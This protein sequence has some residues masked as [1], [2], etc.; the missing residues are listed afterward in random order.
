MAARVGLIA[1]RDLGL[2]EFLAAFPMLEASRPSQS[3][4][5]TWA[6]FSLF[7]QSGLAGPRA[8]ETLRALERPS[9]QAWTE[10]GALWYLAVYPLR[11][12][13]F[14]HV[15]YFHYNAIAAG[16]EKAPKSQSLRK[17][18]ERYEES[19]LE[20]YRYA[21]PLPEGPVPR[22]MDEHLRAR[23]HALSNAL[24]ACGVR[25]ERALLR[26]AIAGGSVSAEEWAWDVGNLPRLADAIGLGEAFAGWRD[27]LEEERSAAARQ[28]EL[29]EAAR[30]APKPDRVQPILDR[31]DGAEPAPVR[32]GPVTAAPSVL[33]LLPWSCESEVEVGFIVRPSRA[34]K[35]RWPKGIFDLSAIEAGGEW[36][37][38]HP[39]CSVWLREGVI[40]KLGKSFAALPPGT[41]LELVSAD[42]PESD[43][44][45]APSAAASM[46]FRGVIE[47][48]KWK[49]THA[50]P[51]V[52]R[53]ELQ[54]ALEIFEWI[55]GRTALSTRSAA[56]AAAVVELGRQGG[57]FGNEKKDQPV[58]S[59]RTIKV[60]SRHW[61]HYLAMT[62]F[63]HR[64]AEG[65]WDVRSAQ[66]AEQA[67]QAEFDQMLETIGAKL[68]Q[69]FAAPRDE[70]AVFEG[71]RSTFRRAD[72]LRVRSK[73][74]L[75]DLFRR[76]YPASDT[77]QRVDLQQAVGIVDQ[78]MV[79]QGMTSMG[80]MVCEA[81]GD[82]V[83]RGYAREAG[84]VY[85]LT[86]AGTT[87]QFIY[88]FNTRFTDGS[89]LTTSIHHGQ[90]R[91]ELKFHHAQF[92][93][94]PVEELLAHHLAAVDKRTTE[95]VKPA[96]HPVAL[97]TLAERIDDFLMR[98][99]A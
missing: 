86:Y 45:G 77:G 31:L 66:A 33:W 2:E 48:G 72:I 61:R 15:H 80:D 7:A 62:F 49:I 56:E 25:H 13:F 27:E 3:G 94:A 82:I 58:V 20:D 57:H 40:Q 21:G 75:R 4:G 83:I 96:P 84:D 76:L 93:N 29:H 24:A 41:A 22:A 73:L 17:L 85:G 51:R 10:D 35:P 53:R 90:N 43:A 55:P 92:P 52:T 60:R 44:G 54:A 5:W 81:F 39:W 11:H 19:V 37:I 91:K 89:A 68:N 32:G 88:E 36:R 65:P 97:A 16:R 18:I 12:K 70:E 87:G 30:K 69:A 14:R 74:D 71:R 38:G 95:K 78:A 79:R 63:R 8:E 28:R 34:A 23:A 50:Y 67:S 59:G 47:R 64:F 26:D 9:L 98:T 6:S 46:R 42:V 99:A 1:V